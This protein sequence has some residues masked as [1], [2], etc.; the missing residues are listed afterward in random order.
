MLCPKCGERLKVQ[1]SRRLSPH[2][3]YREYGCLRCKVAF[4]S[5]EHLD[6]VPIRDSI[7]KVIMNDRR[8][9]KSIHSK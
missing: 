1:E 4:Y 8:K 2:S 5:E 9:H 7:R 3:R 6:P